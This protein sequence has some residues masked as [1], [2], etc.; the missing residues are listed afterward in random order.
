M[1][2]LGWILGIR[3]VWERWREMEDSKKGREAQGSPAGRERQLAQRCMLPI[4]GFPHARLTLKTAARAS[5]PSCHC[6][7]KSR[8][9][10][11][12]KLFWHRW[13]QLDPRCLSHLTL[14]RKGCTFSRGWGF[15]LYMN[16]NRDHMMLM[17]TACSLISQ[18]A[19]N[20][21]CAFNVSN[22]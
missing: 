22:V 2:A 13:L 3:K 8:Q 1:P 18:I 17:H 7:Q 11:R 16:E 5:S 4:F 20:S 12:L 9:E 14:P 10:E 19:V 15:L 6:W 21:C